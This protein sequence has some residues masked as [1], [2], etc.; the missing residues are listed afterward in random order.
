LYKQREEKISDFRLKSK[1]F[2]KSRTVEKIANFLPIYLLCLSTAFM[3]VSPPHYR[4]GE[5][6]NFSSITFFFITF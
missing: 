6:I 2:L 4:G 5:H 1:R 3:M